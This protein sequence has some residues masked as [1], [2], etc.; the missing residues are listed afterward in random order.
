[1]YYNTLKKERKMTATERLIAVVEDE[2]LTNK[3]KQKNKKGE[4]NENKFRY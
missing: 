3:K 1:M 2:I 4:K